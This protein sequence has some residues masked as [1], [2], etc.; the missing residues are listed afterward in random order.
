MKTWRIGIVGGLL[1]V[2]T[3]AAGEEKAEEKTGE[4][5]R[6]ARG[7]LQRNCLRCHDG[8]GSAGGDFD[9]LDRENLVEKKVLTPGNV[10]ASRLLQKIVQGK[11][12]PS[13]ETPR[14]GV[15]E[16]GVLWN[17]IAAGAPA[18][19]KD[20]AN[21]PFTPL[22][23]V[24]AAARA[25]LASARDEDRPNLRYF[26]LHNVAN[27]RGVS[28]SDLNV[29]RAALA[30]ALNSLSREPRLVLPRAVDAA[31]TVYAVDI[32]RLGWN[33]GLLWLNVERAYPY[34]VHHP[35]T[36]QVEDELSERTQADLPVI[37]ADWFIAT[38]LR[39][40]LYH[41]LLRL[42]EQLADLE[43]ELGVDPVARFLNPS[44]ETIARA[45]FARSG[46]SGQNRLVERYDTRDRSYY[47]PS[48]DFKPGNGRASLTRFPLGPLNLFPAGR[49]PFAEQ[50]FVHDGGEI[51]FG[52]PNGLQAYLLVNTEGKRI[53]VGPIDVVNDALRTSGTSEI[54]T[55]VSCMACHK[56]GMIDFEDTIRAN[57]AVFGKPLEQ[58]DRLYP[59][60]A[61]M[62]EF[63]KEDTDRFLAALEK[64]IGP[65][66][67]EGPEKAR[68]IRDF[69]EP[70]AEVARPYRL[71]YLD[72]AAVARELDLDDP[73]RLEAEVGRTGLKRLGL[74]LL[75]DDGVV[76]RND[77]EA[78]LQGLSLMQ[79]LAR[80]LRLPP[81]IPR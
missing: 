13:G 54:V 30:K 71:G 15:D 55:G 7:V 28:E 41:V 45:G 60:K 4:L 44:P 40:P 39:P 69:P 1:S 11:M 62:D 14:P 2:L 49:H 61:R 31:R 6:Q 68:P 57:N 72:L 66:L 21:R 16:V 43:R 52:L 36:R 19:P 34:G 64:T 38:A 18:F 9:L 76:S 65:F 59:A 35:D 25:D 73:A 51:I 17:W 42:P 70:V 47:W 33:R 79:Q 27:D 3:G 63:L 46:V 10:G 50:A 20:D 29:A 5:A 53:D 78:R 48:Y 32:A 26:T 8:E 12:P 67:R 56:H 23:T 24:L 37:R 74:D 81:L 77:W 22:A 75:L 58:L 80:Q